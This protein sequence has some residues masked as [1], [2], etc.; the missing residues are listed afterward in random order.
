MNP[1][2]DQEVIETPVEETVDTSTPEAEEPTN[3]QD[4]AAKIAELEEKNRRLYARLKREETKPAP[5]QSPKTDASMSL[6]DI[7]AVSKAGIEPED[8]QEVQ[9]YAKFK[10]ISLAEALKAPVIKS[11]LADRKQERETAAATSVKGTARGTAKLSDDS[12]LAMA[13]KGEMPES[14]ADIAR[15]IALRRT[16]R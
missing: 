10:G 14:D 2:N 7:V 1:T 13:R 12:L 9:D 8:L 5:A 6:A 3:S 11:T 4:L 15:L 16:Q